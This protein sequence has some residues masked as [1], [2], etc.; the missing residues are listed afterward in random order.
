MNGRQHVPD[1]RT[2]RSNRMVGV[3]CA[4]VFFGMVGVAYAAVP[5]Y[6]MFCQLTGYGGTTQRAEQAP[7]QAGERTI[8]I[9]FNADTAHNLPWSFAPA[10]R[11]TLVVFYAF[12]AFA[13]LNTGFLDPD[14]SCAV[15][16]AD[17][18]LAAARLPV[19]APGG[20]AATALI[21]TTVLVE[22]AIPLLLAIPPTRHAGVLL[23]L[24]FH[25]LV[26]LDLA[27]HFRRQR[28]RQI[29]AQRSVIRVLIA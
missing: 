8:E 27:Q 21:V 6:T 1:P 3:V 29:R 4:G 10:A 24:A 9:R 15:F 19:L 23:G 7:G 28:A 12:A 22:L 5:L 20:V 14:T 26:S 13:K 16:Y 25:G 18:A 17:Q 2:T 11:W